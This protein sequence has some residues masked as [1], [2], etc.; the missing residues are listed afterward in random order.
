MDTREIVSARAGTVDVVAIVRGEGTLA[1]DSRTVVMLSGGGDSV[2]LAIV[3]AEICGAGAVTALHVNYGLRGA[4]SD[5]DEAFCR[6]LCER[7]G[8]ELVVERVTLARGRNLHDV[9]REERYRLARDLAERRDCAT[10]AVAHNAD[11]RAETLLYR[12]VASP[13]RRALLGMPRQRGPIVRP[14]IGFTRRQ[15]REWLASRGER[16]REDSA[17]VDPRFARTRVR[18][19]LAELR[20]VHPAALE[21]ILRT[22]DELAEEAEALDAVVDDLLKRATEAGG[23]S[24]EELRS[25]PEPL[26]GL[27]LR[28]FVERATGHPVPAARRALTRVLEAGSAGG[29]REIDVEGARLLVEYGALRVM[30]ELDEPAPVPPPSV[31]LPVPGSVIFGDWRI[32]ARPTGVSAPTG[33]AAAAN[34]AASDAAS[35]AERVMLPPALARDLSIRTRRPGDRIRPRGLGGSKS[36]QDLFVDR[37]LPRGRRDRQPIVCAG[38]E[39][40]WVPGVAVGERAIEAPGAGAETEAVLITATPLRR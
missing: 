16:W 5:A 33:D 28:E 37:K 31:N 30:G 38:Q 13:G 25:M 4:E 8:V 22:A 24:V 6:Q 17:N 21:N 20:E 1:A 27:V 32:E 11:D 3:A 39:I 34:D 10:I 12:L 36:L 35:D 18:A 14:L 40:V 15:L 23:L 29:S 9:A 19:A 26:A 7:L 2:A